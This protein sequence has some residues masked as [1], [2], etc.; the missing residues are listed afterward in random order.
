MTKKFF[1]SLSLIVAFGIYA[2]LSQAK[3]IYIA[4]PGGQLPWLN[5]GGNQNPKPNPAPT[6]P[7]PSPAPTPAPSPAPTPPPAPKPVGQYIDGFYTGSVA[8]AYYGYVQVKAIISGGKITDVQFLNYPQDRS[9]SREINSQAMPYLT[10]EAIQA[11]SANVDTVSG[12]T[13]TSRAF[14]ESLSSALAQA[15]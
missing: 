14:R 5:L 2:I 4:T 3:D 10:Q 11:Q 9:T 1:L 6:E 12:A 15:K 13:E 8:D 7:P